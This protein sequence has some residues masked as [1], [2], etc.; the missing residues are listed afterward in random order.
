MGGGDS[1]GAGPHRVLPSGFVMDGWIDPTTERAPFL[2]SLGLAPL[3]FWLRSLL[4]YAS[5]LY[6]FRGEEGRQLVRYNTPPLYH[7]EKNVKAPVYFFCF[8]EQKTRSI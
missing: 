5:I 2:S 3:V 6:S 1:G 7:K 8:T 4:V